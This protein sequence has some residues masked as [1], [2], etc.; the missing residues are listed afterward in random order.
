MQ[1]GDTLGL[2]AA[3]NI[4]NAPWSADH[5][6]GE[7]RFAWR[8]HSVQREG[9]RGTGRMQ[10]STRCGI[11]LAAALSIL[12][13]GGAYAAYDPAVTEA[14]EAPT[15]G[16]DIAVQNRLYCLALAVYFEGGSTAETIE[17][18]QYIARV[19]H[20]RARDRVRKWGGGDICEVV[21]YKRKGVCQFS[22]TCLEKARQ[23]PRGGARW[24]LAIRYYMNPEL[25]SDRNACRFRK[26]FV[27]V[28][29]AGRHEF[30]REPTAEERAE[31]AKSPFAPCQRYAAALEAAKQ[32]AKAAAARK[33]AALARKK[34]KKYARK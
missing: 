29:K 3:R 18:Q 22:F 4:Y 13:A 7:E 8:R 27:P 19:V 15:E 30:F 6:D 20:A 1:S 5:P 28:A 24:E 14:F 26:E 23:T 16:A 9:K 31:L 34:A 11:A 12:V 10:P 2:L 32:K 17:G 33:R 21:F 25:T